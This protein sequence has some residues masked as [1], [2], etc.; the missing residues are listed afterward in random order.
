MLTRYTNQQAERT[1]IETQNSQKCEAHAHT[2]ACGTRGWRTACGMRHTLAAPTHLRHARLA[3]GPRHAPEPAPQDRDTRPRRKT[4][5]LVFSRS[6]AN[7]RAGSSTIRFFRGSPEAILAARRSGPFLLRASQRRSCRALPDAVLATFAQRTIATAG[8]C[9][10]VLTRAPSPPSTGK[11]M[12]PRSG[13]C[14][15]ARTVEPKV[16]S[17]GIAMKL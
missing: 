17:C 9:A 1:G 12:S 15:C 5:K 3:H 2:C 7:G 14:A 6:R 4:T 13:S 10:R 11:R 16:R 8:P